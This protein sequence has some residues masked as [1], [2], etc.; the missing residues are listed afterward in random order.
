MVFHS[1]PWTPADGQQDPANLSDLMGDED[2]QVEHTLDMEA[3]LRRTGRICPSA[4][5][6]SS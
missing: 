4:N 6:G 2:P 3:V 5:S 1:R